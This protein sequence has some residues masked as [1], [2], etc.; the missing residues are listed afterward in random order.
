MKTV[1]IKVREEIYKLAE[2]MIKLGLAENRNQA[3][4]KILEL[5]YKKALLLV[6]KK[7]KVL[8]LVEKFMKEGLPYTDLPT[9]LDAIRDRE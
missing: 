2:D 3:F 6:E 7:K 5:G 9:S 1:T 8:N 4:N